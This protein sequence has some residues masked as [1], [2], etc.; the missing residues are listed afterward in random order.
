MGVEEGGEQ[1]VL[2]SWRL[3]DFVMVLLVVFGATDRSCPWRLWF[4]SESFGVLSGSSGA[5]LGRPGALL[6]R[7]GAS[8]RPETRLESV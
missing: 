7:F 4:F 8:W 1:I 6:C 5:L 3:W 2:F